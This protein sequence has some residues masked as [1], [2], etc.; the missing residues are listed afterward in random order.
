M[1][2]LLIVRLKPEPYVNRA[3]DHASVL[4][5]HLNAFSEGDMELAFRNED[6]LLFGFYFRSRQDPAILA[7]S[8]TGLTSFQ[9]GD[10]LMI[11]EV[12]EV[13]SNKGMTTAVTWLQHH[14]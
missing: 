5:G 9:G 12:G 11:V 8:L 3:R 10:A 6:G 2:Y 7:S 14:R 13:V 1:R 4:L